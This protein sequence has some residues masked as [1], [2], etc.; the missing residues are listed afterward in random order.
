MIVTTVGTHNYSYPTFD[1]ILARFSDAIVIGLVDSPRPSPELLVHHS[2]GRV[3][4]RFSKETRIMSDVYDDA[5]FAVVW[6]GDEDFETVDCGCWYFCEPEIRAITVDASPGLIA[7]W[8]AVMVVKKRLSEEKDR[9]AWEHRL[10]VQAEAEAK[11]PKVGRTV[12]VV[13][14][15][16]VAKGT[17]GVCFWVGTGRYGLRV[18]LKTAEGDTVWVDGKNVEAV[19]K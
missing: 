17:I 18:G 8:E 7:V 1:Q 11:E 14:G 10:K 15:R 3:V 16:K 12:R 5:Q 13:R 2:F 6:K 9:L 19:G 4:H